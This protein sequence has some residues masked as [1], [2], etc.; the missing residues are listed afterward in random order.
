M[1][2]NNSKRTDDGGGD[3]WD[4]GAVDST[5]RD[6]ISFV[7][8]RK[9]HHFFLVL[10]FEIFSY[11][12]YKTKNRISRIWVKIDKYIKNLRHSSRCSAGS[13]RSKQ[14]NY[15]RGSAVANSCKAPKCH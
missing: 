14:G 7:L 5:H 15:S 1:S 13:C 10:F 3:R 11:L 12:N 6:V 8:G 4:D 9:R 2:E